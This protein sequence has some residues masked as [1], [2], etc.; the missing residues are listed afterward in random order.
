MHNFFLLHI[1]LGGGVPKGPSDENQQAF[2]KD[3][4]DGKNLKKYGTSHI[5]N[6]DSVTTQ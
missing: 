4:Y 5:I 3:I 2:P 1:S 6:K